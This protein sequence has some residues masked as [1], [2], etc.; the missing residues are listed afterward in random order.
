MSVLSVSRLL[1]VKLTANLKNK[2]VLNTKNLKVKNE[3]FWDCFAVVCT[4]INDTITIM[5]QGN[6][7][8]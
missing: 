5:I 4:F 7:E 1:S 8:S 6:G 3:Y 2:K